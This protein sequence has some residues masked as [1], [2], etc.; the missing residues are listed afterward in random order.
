MDAERPGVVG[1]GAP[2]VWL[3]RVGIRLFFSCP[4]SVVL[5]L[6]LVADIEKVGGPTGRSYRLVPPTAVCGMT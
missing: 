5:Q 1:I 6:W 3:V 4:Y 2:V